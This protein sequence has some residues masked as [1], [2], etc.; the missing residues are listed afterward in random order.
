MLVLVLIVAVIGGVVL[1]WAAYESL[2]DSNTKKGQLAGIALGFLGVLLFGVATLAFVKIS[3]NSVSRDILC[4]SG[5]PLSHE[6]SGYGAASSILATPANDFDSDAA[7]NKRLLQFIELR[8]SLAKK[9]IWKGDLAFDT[10][11]VHLLGIRLFPGEHPSEVQYAFSVNAHLVFADVSCQRIEA[12]VDQLGGRV[13][14][15]DENPDALHNCHF[16]VKAP[17]DELDPV[18][19]NPVSWAKISPLN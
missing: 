19:N 5:N 17:V 9:R 13:V 18:K 6:C 14:Y 16:L 3:V 8:Q 15:A 11:D 10:G 2:T 12:R 1:L 7:K 4:L